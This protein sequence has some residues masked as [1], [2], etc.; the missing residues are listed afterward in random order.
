MVDMRINRQATAWFP[1]RSVGSVIGAIVALTLFILSSTAVAEEGDKQAQ[2]QYPYYY[3]AYGSQTYPQQSAP[4]YGSNPYSYPG[5]APRAYQFP[6]QRQKKQSRSGGGFG[7]GSNRSSRP[8]SGGSRPQAQVPYQAA[9]PKYSPPEVFANITEKRPYVQQSLV[10]ELKIISDANLKKANPVL[11]EVPSVIVKQLEGPITYST[12]RSGG[13]KI[14]T[15]YRYLMMPLQAG[16]MLLPAARITGS[17]ATDQGREGPAFD[18]VAPAGIPLRVRP[19]EKETQPWLPLYDLRIRAKPISAAQKVAG[20]PI[21]LTVEI[22]AEGTTG[23]QLPGIEQQLRSEDYRIYR[24]NTETDGGISRDGRRLQGRRVETF[25][26]VPEYGGLI[27]IPAIKIN[28][29]NIANNRPEVAALP[30]QSFRVKG[31]ARPGSP[32]IDT[33]GGGLLRSGYIW[34]PLIFV[35]IYLLLLWLWSW[36]GNR[37][38]NRSSAVSAY[39]RSGFQALFGDYYATVSAR[40]IRLSPSRQLHRLRAWIGR[41][42]PVSWKLWFCLRAVEQEDDPGEWGQA[43]QILAAKHLGVPTNASLPLLG[44]SIAACHPRADPE[45]VSSLMG[46]LD[47]AV[48]GTQPIVDFARWKKE[49]KRQIKPSLF[50]LRFRGGE[51]EIVR[52]RESV[53]LPDLN[54]K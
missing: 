7:M 22:N 29:W 4:G 47:R 31:E 27:R 51:C 17:H 32:S 39:M 52:A 42:L 11:P 16:D 26:L 38:A 8:Q 37:N 9:K 24:E 23:A 12:N 53:R 2:P 34:L 21:R 6:P 5:Q 41:K 36:W 1:E 3:P 40:L 15:E 28:W 50:R 46:E 43:L 10:Y 45:A 14:V 44:R 33:A 35:A 48:Y 18:V 30:A 54:P 25:T 20:E 13:R 19:A 49:L